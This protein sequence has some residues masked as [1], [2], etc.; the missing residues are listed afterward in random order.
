VHLNGH[1]AMT[2]ALELTGHLRTSA[3]SIFL[4]LFL[5]RV[6][7]AIPVIARNALVLGILQRYMPSAY[8]TYCI[9]N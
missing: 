4:S 3:S 7:L 5:V 8:L 2:H 6:P 9:P 1:K